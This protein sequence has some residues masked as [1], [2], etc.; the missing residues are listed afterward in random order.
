MIYRRFRDAAGA[1]WSASVLAGVLFGATHVP[2]PV[3]VPATLLWGA[4]SARMFEHRPAIVP[5][6]LLQTLLSALLLW[7]TPADWS[8]QFRVGP[9][10]W[11]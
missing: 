7:L 3:L 4:V 2:N 8:H 11:Y 10:Y 1:S 6:A 5:I 9:G